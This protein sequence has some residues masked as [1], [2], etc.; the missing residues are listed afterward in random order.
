MLDD[1]SGEALQELDVFTAIQSHVQWKLRL[2][3]YIEGTSEEVLEPEVVG[4]DNL[5]ALGKWIY[6]HGA[7]HYGDH[8]K[9]QSLKDI[10]AE[11]HTYASDVVRAVHSGDKEH[12]LHLLQQGEYPKISNRIKSVLAGLSLESDFN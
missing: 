5:C 7:E 1:I 8:P 3:S 6:S 10:H 2:L 11:F 12:A 9:F 4:S